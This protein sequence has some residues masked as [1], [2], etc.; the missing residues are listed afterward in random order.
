M[1]LFPSSLLKDDDMF[2]FPENDSEKKEWM[3]V[4]FRCNIPVDTEDSFLLRNLDFCK[5]LQRVFS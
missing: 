5:N 2:W 4:R 1:F 3:N